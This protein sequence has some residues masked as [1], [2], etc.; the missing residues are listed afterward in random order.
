VKKS[1]L[2]LYGT[3]L[4]LILLSAACLVWFKMHQRLGA[5]GLRAELPAKV[6][7]YTAEAIQPTPA[8]VDFLPADTT[9]RRSVY[10]GVRGG[11]TNQIQLTYVLM[12]SDRTSIHKPQF[13]L[14]GQGW[15]IRTSEEVLI[16]L[17]RPR[18]Y[19][20]PIMKLTADKTFPGTSPGTAQTY[21]GLYLY[22]FVAENALTA[23]HGERM[24][25]M[26]K[27][28]LSSGELQRWAYVSCFAM[29]LPGQ[30]EATFQRMREFIQEA[31]PEFQITPGGEGPRA[32]A[33]T[34]SGGPDDGMV[35]EVDHVFL[36]RMG[37]AAH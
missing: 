4:G 32:A 28:L 25:L 6:L 37:G 29:C 1:S 3:A 7:E 21:K 9:L 22:W 35:G 18:P 10:T 17:K 19:E 12:G 8:E 27:H 2:A 33:S 24:W 20:L 14:T 30:E 15:Q 26:A 5:P 11:E 36:R 16:P 23:R 34:R 13:C 31:T